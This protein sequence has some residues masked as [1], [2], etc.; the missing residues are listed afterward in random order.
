[1][2]ALAPFPPLF[3]LLLSCAVATTP[4]IMTINPTTNTTSSAAFKIL[5]RTTR[6]PLVG[7]FG[8][9]RLS[10]QPPSA[11]DDSSDADKSEKRQ[12]TERRPIEHLEDI[13]VLRNVS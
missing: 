4:T 2:S 12:D 11:V 3:A 7:C 6:S 13:V 9:R 10:T 8:G 5:Y 1:M